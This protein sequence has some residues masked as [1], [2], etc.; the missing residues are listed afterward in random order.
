MFGGRRSSRRMQWR[1]RGG[2]FGN[3]WMG[4]VG[5]GGA[6]VGGFGA[7]PAPH[8]SQVG[9]MGSGAFQGSGRSCTG[10]SGGWTPG[11]WVDRCLAVGTVGR[12]PPRPWSGRRGATEARA[13]CIGHRFRGCLARNSFESPVSGLRG[14]ACSHRCFSGLLVLRM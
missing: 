8:P 7:A 9:R 6:A 1:W 4:G 12:G 5:G 2:G 14:L 3:T 10:C 13:D 11:G